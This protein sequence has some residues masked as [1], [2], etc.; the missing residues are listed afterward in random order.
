MISKTDFFNSSKTPYDLVKAGQRIPRD[1]TLLSIENNSES[2][3]LRVDRLE[4][5][6]IQKNIPS[7]TSWK[8]RLPD[9]ELADASTTRQYR[10]GVYL[11][12]ATIETI[13]AGITTDTDHLEH[14]ASRLGESCHH[15]L[16]DEKGVT[17]YALTVST[18]QRDDFFVRSRQGGGGEGCNMLIDGA[19]SIPDTLTTL[20]ACALQICGYSQQNAEMVVRFMLNRHKAAPTQIHLPAQLF[21]TP[22]RGNSMVNSV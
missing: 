16:F 18:W 14:M 12:P 6:G 3:V 4:G 15:I 19:P 1:I 7:T 22:P 9:R 10:K 17:S 11:P 8:P 20:G 13:I 5:I 2:T 21:P